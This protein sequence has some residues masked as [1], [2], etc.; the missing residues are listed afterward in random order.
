MKIAIW[1]YVVMAQDVGV[2]VR[3]EEVE[4][5]EEE[6]A[7]EKKGRGDVLDDKG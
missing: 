5:D 6:S 1:Y 4:V 7:V 3:I 2:G